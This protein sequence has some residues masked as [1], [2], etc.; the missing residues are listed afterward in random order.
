MFV[1]KCFALFFEYV[2]GDFFV[3]NVKEL[4]FFLFEMSFDHFAEDFELGILCLI[5]QFCASAHLKHVVDVVVFFD[6]L[7]HQGLVFFIAAFN[8]RLEISSLLG[9]MV[10]LDLEV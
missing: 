3:G 8:G 7:E 10:A 9:L 2:I 6:H 5:G 1:F 4:I